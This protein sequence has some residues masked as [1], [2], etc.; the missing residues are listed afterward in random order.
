MDQFLSDGHNF[1][2]HV[3]SFLR[4]TGFEQAIGLVEGAAFEHAQDGLVAWKLFRELL[5]E[6]DRLIKFGFC[7][8][9]FTQF[10][11]QHGV[12]IQNAREREL[13]G[14]LVG[15]GAGDFGSHRQHL[16]HQSSGFGQLPALSM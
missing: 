10:E 1:H 2:H 11:K 5:L 7:F 16:V 4:A 8:W 12:I 6:R 3:N 13:V 15:P 14:L 9:A